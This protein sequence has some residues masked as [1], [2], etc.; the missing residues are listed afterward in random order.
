MS[1]V[2]A[3]SLVAAPQ[4]SIWNRVVAA[5]QLV[6]EEH[7]ETLELSDPDARRTRQ[8][9]LGHR[10][11]EVAPLVPWPGLRAEVEA[12]RGRL[13]GSDY[14]VGPTARALIRKIFA[15]ASFRRTPL[16]KP[17]L[18]RGKKLYEQSCAACHGPGATGDSAIGKA[19][20]PPAPDLLHPRQNWSPY[21][22]FLRTT[23]GGAQ[24]AMPSFE[25]G[26]TEMQ[27]WAIVF[28]LFAAR[29]PPCEKPLPPLRADE[30]ALL[31]DYELS[32]RFG[33]GAASCLRR[34]FIAPAQPPSRESSH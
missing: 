10:L 24:T 5:L 6:A 29:W 20:D 15:S 22:M 34:D 3:F 2:L 27:R 7:H 12:L 25:E 32:K 31:G 8:L 33:Y 11:E 17:D 14:E 21:D 9:Q 19:M 18:A 1:V 16:A 28:H 30:L 26:L 23:Y 13:V 4:G